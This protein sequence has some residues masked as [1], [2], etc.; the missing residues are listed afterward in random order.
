M[1]AAVAILVLGLLLSGPAQADK[2]FY[3]TDPSGHV[4]VPCGLVTVA[5]DWDFATSDHGFTT[6]A[7][8]VS[9]VPTWEYG[10]T[11]YIPGAPSGN[12]WGT[13]LEAD[14]A[15][16][17]GESLVSP[18][19]TVDATTRLLE[20]AHYY[21]AEN[22]W[23]GGN[24]TVDGEV[25][26]PLTGYPGVISV[27]SGWTAWCVDFEEG[28]TGLDSGWLTSCFDLSAFTGQVI[29]VTFDFGSDVSFVEAGWYISAVR[30]GSDQAVPAES[31]TFG[32]I[33]AMYR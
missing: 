23:D 21:D 16:D 5:H 12:V 18:A 33:K 31:R 17:S 7:C 6:D 26:T 13:V 30:L 2:V 24:V 1:L 25:I 11:T 14:Y 22:L 8:D 29:Q 10:V 20:V 27:P 3:P 19:F 4:R 15:T 32:A 9:G 28:F